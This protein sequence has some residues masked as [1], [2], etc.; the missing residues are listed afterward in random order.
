[1]AGKHQY[2]SSLFIQSGSV[3]QFKS[4]IT[5]S[6]LTV[7]GTVYAN[8]YYDLEGNQVGTGGGG[9]VSEFFAGSG[10]GVS[11][12]SDNGG[13]I[14]VDHFLE[15]DGTNN[16]V[17]SNFANV[18]VVAI[19]ATGSSTFKPNYFNF[20]KVGDSGSDL[21]TVK[22]GS[23]SVY[24]P[25]TEAERIAGV[26]RYIVYG[27][28]T[29]S[30]GETHQLFHT[31]T[32]DAFSNNAPTIVLPS[33]T[34]LSMSLE[35]DK[36]AL[37]LIVHF[38]GSTDQNQVNGS[39]DWIKEFEIT[40]N[41]PTDPTITSNTD[42]SDA[43]DLSVN[44][45]NQ[46]Q[47]F[48][49]NNSFLTSSVFPGLANEYS[50]NA[51]HF[52][53]SLVSYNALNTNA[54]TIRFSTPNDQG[55]T[56][57]LQDNFPEDTT[58]PGTSTTDFIIPV[59]PPP[60]ASIKNIRI[61][62]EGNNNEGGFS[63][64]D[65]DFH[66]HQVLYDRTQ[67][68]TA[69][70]MAS[71]TPDNG[72]P[73]Y[74]YT[75][76]IVRIQSRADIVHPE[77]ISIG[78]TEPYTP[79]SSHT[80][81][82]EILQRSG[83]G[84]NSISYIDSNFFYFQF[85]SGSTTAS[86]AHNTANINNTY[87]SLEDNNYKSLTFTGITQG[88]GDIYKYFGGINDG[89]TSD[90]LYINDIT[91][92][93]HGTNDHYVAFPSTKTARQ[94][95]L[96]PVSN[97]DVSNI[98]VEVESSS[99]GTNKGTINL[100]SSILYGLTSSL[101]SSQTE[102][103]ITNILDNGNSNSQHLKYISQS[104]VRLRISATVTEPYGPDHNAV[105]FVLNDNN[106]HT[107]NID[108]SINSTDVQSFTSELDSTNKLV[109]KYTSSWQE[110]QF[111]PGE[112]L[113]N[114]TNVSSPTA[115]AGIT[116]ASPI[117]AGISMSEALPIK[118]EDTIF[119][120]ETYGFSN[121]G[122][123]DS[124]STR[125]VLAGFDHRT[126][127]NDGEVEGDNALLFI[128]Q[129]LFRFRWKT[130]MI[131]P[132][133][134]G[135]TKA[136]SSV[137][138]N[139][140]PV[141][142]FV[143]NHALS[144][145]IIPDQTTEGNIHP[146]DLLNSTNKVSQSSDYNSNGE[147]ITVFT[148]SWIS[149][150]VQLA[151]P[152]NSP[153][154]F[155]VGGSISCS[156]E[157][158]DFIHGVDNDQTQAFTV[159]L[160]SGSI[161]VID[162]AVVL[163]TNLAYETEEFGHAAFDENDEGFAGSQIR[164][165]LYGDPHITNTDSGSAIWTN[166]PSASLYASQSVTR[167]RI[168][169]RVIEPLGPNHQSVT[170][171]K[172]FIHT[173]G[174]IVGNTVTFNTSSTT[175]SGSFV[176]G[177]KFISDYT[178][179]W[180]GQQLT[181]TTN[182]Y[183]LYN[184][185]GY[186]SQANG[187]S[188]DVYDGTSTTLGTS[189]QTLQ[190]T[191]HDTPKTQID[192]VVYSTET[193]GYSN[194]PTQVTFRK[195]LYGDPHVTNDG[196]GSGES[197]Y[198]WRNYDE[199]VLYASQSVTRFRVTAD[200]IEPMGYL[201]TASRFDKQFISNNFLN[202]N[203]YVHFSTNSL[204]VESFE[205][206]Y[207][208][209]GEFKVSYTSSWVGQKLSSSNHTT[210]EV[211]NYGSSPNIF[212]TPS[213]ENAAQ[214]L[215]TN[216]STIT[217][218]DTKPV[219]VK[220]F[221][222]ESEPH[223]LDINSINDDGITG[224]TRRQVL[225]GHDHTVYQYKNGYNGHTYQVQYASQSLVRGR[226]KIRLIEPVG[227]FKGQYILPKT[228]GATFF[229]HTGS[230]WF[231]SKQNYYT[232][233][234]EGNYIY[235]YTSSFDEL[236]G[237]TFQ[238]VIPGG[239]QGAGAL[240]EKEFT[241]SGLDKNN[242]YYNTVAE[243][244]GITIISPTTTTFQIYDTDATQFIDTKVETE[245]FGYNAHDENDNGVSPTQGSPLLRTVLY[246]DSH[247]TN[248]GTGSGESLENYSTSPY[249]ASQSVTRFRIKTTIK[250]PLG[251]LH[252]EYK[253][254][255][256]FTNSD[257]L[258]DP[259]NE[260]ISCSDNL[261][262]VHT[263]SYDSSLRKTV[264][265]TSDWVGKQLL[266]QDNSNTEQV[267]TPLI[268]S[269]FLPS[270]ENGTTNNGLT[271]TYL[272]IQDTKP[273]TIRLSKVE[274]ETE[275]ISNVG[276]GNNQ[277]ANRGDISR[278][279]LAGESTT[280]TSA[281]SAPNNIFNP[282]AVTKYRISMEVIEPI[283]FLHH[284]TSIALRHKNFID[285]TIVQSSVE[286]FHTS[287]NLLHDN[288]VGF[289]NETSHPGYDANSFF[290]RYTSSFNG[291]AL[292]A[293]DPQYYRSFVGNNPT[294]TIHDP[295]GEN[296]YELIDLGDSS[297]TDHYLFHTVTGSVGDATSLINFAVEVE[298][299]EYEDNHAA[300][301]TIVID[302]TTYLRRHTNIL[303]SKTVTETNIGNNNTYPNNDSQNQLVRVRMV[304]T[305]QEPVGF[306]HTSVDVTIGGF[307]GIQLISFNTESSD[308]LAGSDGINITPPTVNTGRRTNYTS[309]WIPIALSANGMASTGS[310]QRVTR[311]I[312]HSFG[313]TSFAIENA[314]IS[315]SVVH[316]TGALASTAVIAL[317]TSSI[318]WSSSKLALGDS[319][320]SIYF[321]YNH[322]KAASS[323]GDFSLTL[324]H[325]IVVTPP[326][327]TTTNNI[328]F[329]AQTNNNG[330]PV[331]S[332]QLRI[333]YTESD[334]PSHHYILDSGF[335]S[336]GTGL[337]RID[338]SDIDGLT[339]GL[340]TIP[341]TV[342]AT[343]I[344][345]GNGKHSASK[346]VFIIPA[347]PPTMSGDYNVIS[348]DNHPSGKK[349]ELY[350]GLL[351]S[352]S[353]INYK[354]GEKPSNPDTEKSSSRIFYPNQ[355]DDTYNYSMSFQTPGGF[356][357]DYLNQAGLPD[358]SD[359]AYNL[360]DSGSLIVNI[361]GNE[362]VNVDL[363]NAFSVPSKGG[364]QP[365]YNN[366][367]FTN[368]T[369]SFGGVYAGQGRLILNKVAPFNGVSER[370][371]NAGTFYPNGYQSFQAEIQIDDKLRDGYNY[372]V[373]SHTFG[374]T[375]NEPTQQLDIFDWYYDN[376]ITSPSLI[377][378][379]SMSWENAPSEPNPTHS[380]SGVSYFKSSTAFTASVNNIINL[381][382]K[383]YS[384]KENSFKVGLRTKFN[385]IDITAT[386]DGNDHASEDGKPVLFHRHSGI[387]LSTFN[388]N[389]RRGLRFHEGNDNFIPT[390]ES[391]GSIK[392]EIS[393]VIPTST[394]PIKGKFNY[395][396]SLVGKNRNTSYNSPTSDNQWDDHPLS[397]STNL[398]IG[399]FMHDPS[400][401]SN[402]TNVSYVA[403]SA[404]VEHF[405]LE[406]YRW[407]RATLDDNSITGIFRNAGEYLS[408]F[409]NGSPDYNSI[410][411]ISTTEDLQQTYEGRLRNPSESYAEVSNPNIVD[412]STGVTAQ[413]R[414][415][416]RALQTD[417]TSGELVFNVDVYGSFTLSDL[418][419]T[420]ANIDGSNIRIDVKVP[421]KVGDEGSGWGSI[422]WTSYAQNV[423][424]DNWSA[425]NNDS[426]LSGGRRFKIDFVDKS[427]ILVD[428]VV[429]FRIRYKSSLNSNDYISRIEITTN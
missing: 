324:S 94:L 227:H 115:T 32:I 102:S 337:L 370:I 369:A 218:V 259:S 168:K 198:G 408:F 106:T 185:T 164:T 93:R 113:F 398:L 402:N 303:H 84:N 11:R 14:S 200:I 293:A 130:K 404:T 302:G 33:N 327:H 85:P 17:N 266:V 181:A 290:Q 287:S 7:D 270:G 359:Q 205:Q 167:F 191:I 9:V 414:Y 368:N 416:Y 300:T 328:I 229:I 360:G 53:A 349:D 332:G 184:Y 186:T 136:T 157:N 142:D 392:Y 96:T 394:D 212:H 177:D 292:T 86:T 66:D 46:T 175:Y 254:D 353:L 396:A 3:A 40:R 372:L 133:G 116:S 325:S 299:E 378:N 208:P 388:E 255:K 294:Y 283:G 415:Y 285:N 326:T 127:A 267:I 8:A 119:E 35:H 422:G 25:E 107:Q 384:H 224:N 350:F 339:S 172:Q 427:P 47:L 122:S 403:S 347:Q 344:L 78:S 277:Q 321:T 109:G 203:D 245:E 317:E 338:E 274:T 289:S 202:I 405:F 105:R 409:I 237:T 304:G 12:S 413:D 385:D 207:T 232:G 197:G 211:Y 330:S 379:T 417:D 374:A 21:I 132:F 335:K 72:Q 194:E 128:S 334:N 366:A 19:Q 228:I 355:G 356:T 117:T 171:Q 110:F 419:N 346:D 377:A 410:Q 150:S 75:S 260:I 174:T 149:S 226:V 424:A 36:T 143:N 204:D 92:I 82:I 246:G 160:T 390:A 45:I 343:N 182:G 236:G 319:E 248:D 68:L 262:I 138:I 271:S 100:S 282:T 361:N 256:K 421:G 5:A 56:I 247:I 61:V 73:A 386:G 43:F 281:L 34:Q 120:P 42:T 6:G 183:T 163:I 269:S 220:N 397:G 322:H 58:T 193:H 10:S 387:D 297:L 60:T 307:D 146:I 169:A 4:G 235:D 155:T 250:E 57:R 179:S 89:T 81:K 313:A 29:G 99:F 309:S 399:R 49:S 239:S 249:L 314:P 67:T 145:S 257:G 166:H 391:T 411:N 389:L 223:G 253:I 22:Q 348:L 147:L 111:D 275:G 65:S 231:E 18:G 308:M 362:V 342:T 213:G 268:N 315:H 180:V 76:S 196:T 284:S 261:S 199:R 298:K 178:S 55:F 125:K 214:I 420:S 258:T 306:D 148:S 354:T 242:T 153:A 215:S 288:P 126:L 221:F 159:D 217:I 340:H 286:I 358:R 62:F 401:L 131:E 24:I 88:G 176:E 80:T 341:V 91:T 139:T 52:T 367:D 320:D 101:L 351:A 189:T 141:I 263:P 103:L 129:S 279:I 98:T 264:S 59:I 51:L 241:H 77:F 352:A 123:F 376:G 216:A 265:Y 54:N 418:K 382:N 64:T 375:S 312:S 345:P 311:I 23:S 97:I 48:T 27:A 363:Q 273:T 152:Y 252:H 406:T 104:L 365:N 161:R 144:M 333:K 13:P 2:T 316:V 423:N 230:I 44:H 272:N 154:D 170:I 310:E 336:D 381:A 190:L 135:K 425:Y 187:A 380:L 280:R 70:D 20:L 243:E 87:N 331:T 373:L 371:F 15:L 412:Y 39:E 158:Y 295:E 38:T 233:S 426:A 16:S 210:G 301:D 291:I 383:V 1:M 118:F 323:G 140:N 400:T 222:F 225:Y 114:V 276:I 244:N 134:P 206:S 173:A 357:G 108:F 429:L 28:Q 95:K 121:T 79:P 69:A 251:F 188:S 151:S 165:V 238:I 30:G 240:Y 137:Q 37:D 50:P 318:Y 83:E 219:L 329:G 305:V 278:T 428:N 124:L 31:V 41:T 395:S 407:L 296:G 26:H 195:V 192:N 90:D 393:A 156:G 209:K 162:T 201:H 63:N 71:L 364:T 234:N 74:L 112:Y